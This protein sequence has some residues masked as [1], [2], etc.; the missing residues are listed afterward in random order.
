MKT[1][2]II[3]TLCIILLLGFI[4]KTHV[5]TDTFNNLI[6]LSPLKEEKVK[7]DTISDKDKEKALQE[8]L[9]RNERNL[10][11]DDNILRIYNPEIIDNELHHVSLIFVEKEQLIRIDDVKLHIV[12]DISSNII[13]EYAKLTNDETIKLN[14]ESSYQ[15]NVLYLS[16]EKFDMLSNKALAK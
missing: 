16:Q 7:D 2:N 3:M 13:L 12:D 8:T 5:T 6:Q 10:I 15:A 14:L 1:I 9:S 11:H 4:V